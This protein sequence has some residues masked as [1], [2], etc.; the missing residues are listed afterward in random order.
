MEKRRP[1]EPWEDEETHFF[2]LLSSRDKGVENE[3]SSETKGEERGVQVSREKGDTT[4]ISLNQASAKEHNSE[5][6]SEETARQA[7]ET[8]L[9]DEARR[10][11]RL[12]TDRH[13]ESLDELSQK[14]PGDLAKEVATTI[15]K[16]PKW[17]LEVERG[18]YIYTH[19]RLRKSHGEGSLMLRFQLRRN[20]PIP[21]PDKLEEILD[22]IIEV[23]K[24]S[25]DKGRSTEVANSHELLEKNDSLVFEEPRKKTATVVTNE[26]V[27]TIEIAEKAPE[28][29]PQKSQEFF[30]ESQEIISSTPDTILDRLHEPEAETLIRHAKSE[31]ILP[32]DSEVEH[33]FENTIKDSL[34]KEGVNAS[35]EVWT[36]LHPEADVQL[37]N[38]QEGE[39][40]PIQETS[41]DASSIS[42]ELTSLAESLAEATEELAEI[43]PLRGGAAAEERRVRK[44]DPETPP[45]AKQAE[46]A[47]KQPAPKQSSRQPEFGLYQRNERY[48][49]SEQP[50]TPT[51]RRKARKLARVLARRFGLVLTPELAAYLLEIVLRP[52][53]QGEHRIWGLN[54]NREELIKTL[55]VLWLQYGDTYGR[56]PID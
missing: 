19:L 14:L 45:R 13:T 23:G 35:S 15:D 44:L 16:L 53:A 3:P 52:K 1:R 46:T 56:R 10:I 17:H 8:R 31:G 37:S 49:K 43:P 48:L 4:S 36:T 51:M 50:P 39:P 42:V 54:L 47:R 30:R 34:E 6:L 41:L 33:L 32:S 9:I 21:P 20:R 28:D 40:Q 55:T 11:E 2:D 24:A 27:A 7:A 5:P 12:A 18:R 38:I 29:G 25:T 26:G 22:R